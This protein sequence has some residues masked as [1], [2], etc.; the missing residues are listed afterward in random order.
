MN[1][2]LSKSA[3]STLEHFTGRTPVV[4]VRPVSRSYVLRFLVKKS[5]NILR[6]SGIFWR[7]R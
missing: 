1:N 2:L 6:E 7:D 3:I 5:I 4:P